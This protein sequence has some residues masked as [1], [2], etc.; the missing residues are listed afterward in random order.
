MVSDSVYWLIL[1]AVGLFAAG[2]TIVTAFKRKG[3]GYYLCDDCRF[4]SPSACLK[5]ERPYALECTSYRVGLPAAS[6]ALVTD[7]ASAVISAITTDGDSA[8]HDKVAEEA[9]S[10]SPAE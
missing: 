7:S 9:K 3:K 10:E 1:G 8:P 5:A 6:P 4:N 2:L